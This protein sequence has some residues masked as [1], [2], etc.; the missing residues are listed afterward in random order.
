[1]ALALA[2][3]QTMG[4]TVAEEKLQMQQFCGSFFENENNATKQC[5][6]YNLT[7]DFVYIIFLTATIYFSNKNKLGLVIGNYTDKSAFDHLTL[8][9]VNPY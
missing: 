3:V 8:V 7:S 5:L 1:M 4:R 9:K 6:T 2:P